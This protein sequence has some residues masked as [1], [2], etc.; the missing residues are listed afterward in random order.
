MQIPPVR[1]V[2]QLGE[3]S[4]RPR[5]EVGSE[6]EQKAICCN[7]CKRLFEPKHSLFVCNKCSYAL[8]GDCHRP[9]KTIHALSKPNTPALTT[10]V[11]L[12]L[13]VDL[14]DTSNT[15]SANSSSRSQYNCPTRFD[16]MLTIDLNGIRCNNDNNNNNNNNDDE[17][18]DNSKSPE[19]TRAPSMFSECVVCMEHDKNQLFQPCGHYVCC[20]Q[21]ALHL[22]KGDPTSTTPSLHGLCPICCRKIEQCFRVINS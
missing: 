14:D 7:H 8:C 5:T 20:E 17:S 22:M 13:S 12:A 15:V 1:S 21:C 6:Q 4:R 2:L 11:S 18:S 19:M 9:L 16:S 10:S 3:L